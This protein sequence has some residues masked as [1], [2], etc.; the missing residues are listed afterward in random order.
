MSSYFICHFIFLFHIYHILFY[1]VSLFLLLVL[2]LCWAQGPSI[3]PVFAGPIQ[4][5]LQPNSR[6]N[7]G[8]FLSFQQAYFLQASLAQ[9][10]A[11]REPPGLAVPR[12][13]LHPAATIFTKR[14]DAC[15]AGHSPSHLLLLPTKQ[16]MP[17]PPRHSAY[18][19]SVTPTSLH[20]SL[21]LLTNTQQ[22]QP[23]CR[24]SSTT[25]H[26][27]QHTKHCSTSPVPATAPAVSLTGLRLSRPPIL[28]SSSL[29]PGSSRQHT[30]DSSPNSRL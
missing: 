6:P 4:S 5:I 29:A 17:R 22:Q 7:E 8:P 21:A 19:S 24:T 28:Q 10:Q 25:A 27:P 1:L 3:K 9:V 11:H 15:P 30:Q 16:H 12:A 2:F 20:V 18:T 23:T 26:L 13:R 14:T